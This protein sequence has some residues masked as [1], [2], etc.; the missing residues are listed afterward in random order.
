MTKK[1]MRITTMIH[2]QHVDIELHFNVHVLYRDGM[3]E[4]MDCIRHNNNMYRL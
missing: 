1:A 2:F 3:V 4:D